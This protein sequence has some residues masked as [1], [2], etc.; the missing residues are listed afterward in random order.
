MI[1]IGFGVEE[2]VVVVVVVVVIVVVIVVVVVVV[3]VEVCVVEVGNDGL[4][5]NQLQYQGVVVVFGVVDVV[6]NRSV[7]SD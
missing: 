7:F 6:D 1:N 5:S 3:E 4:S 2:T